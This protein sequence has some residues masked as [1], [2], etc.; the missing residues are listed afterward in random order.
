[1]DKGNEL[2]V[3]RHHCAV[4]RIA[5]KRHR[6]GSPRMDSATEHSCHWWQSG[7]HEWAGKYTVNKEEETRFKVFGYEKQE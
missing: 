2:V 3:N 7:S 4:L 5:G 1:M 6:G